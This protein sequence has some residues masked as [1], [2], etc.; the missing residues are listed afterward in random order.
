V[1]DHR[2]RA[3]VKCGSLLHHEDRCRVQLAPELYERAIAAESRVAALEAERDEAWRA[4]CGRAPGDADD[5]FRESMQD[6]AVRAAFLAECVAERTAAESRSAALEEALRGLAD[7]L[8][9]EAQRI[10]WGDRCDAKMNAA[11]RIRAALAGP[12]DE[13]WLRCRDCGGDLVF[14]APD[15]GLFHLNAGPCPAAEALRAALA[16]GTTGE[17]AP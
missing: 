13:N 11:S 6:P 7:E 8:D 2:E 17:G 14:V 9:E 1:A 4:L 12:P 16:S 5:M 3:C 15:G 10:P